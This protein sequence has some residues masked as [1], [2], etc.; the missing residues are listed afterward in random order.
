MQSFLPYMVAGFGG[1]VAGMVYWE[2]RKHPSKPYGLIISEA[3]IRIQAGGLLSIF[4]FLGGSAL[5]DKYKAR[6]V[7]KDLREF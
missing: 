7:Q 3:R 1:G 2:K 5:Y 4:L 6:S